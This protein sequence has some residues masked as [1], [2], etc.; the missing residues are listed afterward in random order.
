MANC[1]CGCPACFNRGVATVKTKKTST[2]DFDKLL[3]NTKLPWIKVESSSNIFAYA[4]K[5]KS[6]YVQF[7]GG[8][9]GKYLEV[10]EEDFNLLQH[11][12]S[13]GKFINNVIKTK[14]KYEKVVV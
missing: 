2:I 11:A 5:D 9:T 12:V 6:L 14:Y 1:V 3:E 7:I 4:Y 8:G 10:I 13:K